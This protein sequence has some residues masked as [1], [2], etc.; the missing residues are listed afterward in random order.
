MKLTDGSDRL[1]YFKINGAYLPVGCL[2]SAGISESSETLDTTTRDNAG[3]ATSLPVKQEYSLSFSGLQINTTVAGG[4]FTVASYDKLQ[5]LKRTKLL[6]EWKLEGRT[7]PVIDYGKCY[8]TELS[9]EEVAGEFM[10]FSGTAKG[11]GKPLNA[12]LGT[13]VLNNGNPETAIVTDITNETAI[14]TSIF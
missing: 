8:I 13:T 14:K 9:S 7:Y 2:D 12:L 11:F 10:T 1:L 3:W 6:L 5:Q 4:T